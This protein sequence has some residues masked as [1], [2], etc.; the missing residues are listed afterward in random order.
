MSTDHRVFIRTENLMPTY[1]SS[2]QPILDQRY[3]DDY[4]KSQTNTNTDHNPPLQ[5]CDIRL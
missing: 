2:L 3:C 4:N 5:F 1:P